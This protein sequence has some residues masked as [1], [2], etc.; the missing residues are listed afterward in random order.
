MN[1]ESNVGRTEALVIGVPIIL[2]VIFLVLKLYKITDWNWFWIFSPI[3]LPILFAAFVWGIFLI[4][5]K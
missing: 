4:I 2:T 5:T 3:A 1:N